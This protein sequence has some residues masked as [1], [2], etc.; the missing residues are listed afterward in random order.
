MFWAQQR[1]SFQQFM[2]KKKVYET[3]YEKKKASYEIKKQSV[4]RNIKS[5]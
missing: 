1:F 3:E 4:I 2:E 5:I